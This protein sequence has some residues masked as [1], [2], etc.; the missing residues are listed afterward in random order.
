MKNLMKY[1]SDKFKI[2]D[3]AIIL[4]RNIIPIDIKSVTIKNDELVIEIIKQPEVQSVLKLMDEGKKASAEVAKPK[5]APVIN[6]KGSTGT[7]LN[8]RDK[9]LSSAVAQLQSAAGACKT[10]KEKSLINSAKSIIKK[11]IGNP[12]F[13]YMGEADRLKAMYDALTPKEQTVVKSAVLSHVNTEALLEIN[14]D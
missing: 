9:I 14:T 13:A 4:S 6:K 10:S 1:V 12:D 5:E 7:K 11:M 2:S 8:K 3:N